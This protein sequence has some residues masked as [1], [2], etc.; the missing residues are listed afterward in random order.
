MHECDWAVDG[1]GV[2]DIVKNISIKQE[3]E[4]QDEYSTHFESRKWSGVCLV[5]ATVFSEDFRLFGDDTSRTRCIQALHL[6][7]NLFFEFRRDIF[8]DSLLQIYEDRLI[9]DCLNCVTSLFSHKQVQRGSEKQFSGDFYCTF[10][11]VFNIKT[12]SQASSFTF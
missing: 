5:L 1:K 4:R 2:S 10:L 7:V 6:V 8:P 3:V 12:Q 9:P 11:V